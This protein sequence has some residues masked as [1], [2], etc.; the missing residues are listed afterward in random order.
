MLKIEG[1]PFNVVI[2]QCYAPTQDHSDEVIEEYYNEIQECLKLVKSTD[3]LIVMGD[4]NA[5]VGKEETAHITGKFGLGDRNL[6]GER[7]IQFCQ[8]ENLIVTNT[9]YQHHKRRLYT[10]MS[11][12]DQHRNQIDFILVKNCFKNHVKDVRTYPGADAMSD[13]NLLVTKLKLKLKL[14]EKSQRQDSYEVN[15]LKQDKYREQFA[16]EVR[17]RFDALMSKELEQYEKEEDK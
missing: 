1:K 12:G 13:H 17:N 15:L 16:I 7:L 11:P 10:W 5:K 2:V 6:R 9:F 3:D 4:W 8:E 14:P